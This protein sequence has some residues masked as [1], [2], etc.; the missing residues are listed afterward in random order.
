MANIKYGAEKV[1]GRRTGRTI[2]SLNYYTF[3]VGASRAEA[4][5]NLLHMLDEASQNTDHRYIYTRDGVLLACYYRAGS[6][7]Y[8]IV[9]QGEMVTPSCW[10]SSSLS[11]VIERARAHAE[12]SYGGVV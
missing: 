4:L 8:D 7:G 2:A 6:W 12:Q 5:A 3:A 11:E 1:N 9:R 10:G